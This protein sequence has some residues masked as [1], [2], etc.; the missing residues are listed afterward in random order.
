M[1]WIV[2]LL[3]LAGG[4]IGCDDDDESKGCCGG[5]GGTPLDVSVGSGM[6]SLEEVPALWVVTGIR[7]TGVILMGM[8]PALPVIAVAQAIVA[9]SVSIRFGVA[10][11]GA[12]VVVVVAVPF[13]ERTVV[14]SSRGGMLL[15]LLLLLA[16]AKAAATVVAEGFFIGGGVVTDATP[17]TTTNGQKGT[18]GR[19]RSDWDCLQSCRSARNHS[20]ES[21]PYCSCS[22]GCCCR[23]SHRLLLLFL[24]QAAAVG[25]EYSIRLE[26]LLIVG[27]RGET[28][29]TDESLAPRVH[30]W[31]PPLWIRH[32]TTATT[33]I[34]DSALLRSAL[35]IML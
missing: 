23:H 28:Q 10:A 34:L 18:R 27:E 35:L 12:V 29:S 5:G 4:T 7:A 9:S 8:E 1:R 21:R 16:G 17:P 14:S 15:L 24:L 31:F 32:G 13:A 3:L 30:L 26:L 6:I 2:L 22:C 11:K 25:A 20:S 33:R 19:C